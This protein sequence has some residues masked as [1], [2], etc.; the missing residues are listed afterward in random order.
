MHLRRAPGSG[1]GVNNDE[2]REGPTE[3]GD[4]ILPEKNRGGPHVVGPEHQAPAH[5]SGTLSRIA[6]QIE[7]TSSS[8]TTGSGPS[9][10]TL[11]RGSVPE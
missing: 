7:S 9:S 8:T 6:S 4:G 5:D 10:I 2:R 11:A 1:G 3:T